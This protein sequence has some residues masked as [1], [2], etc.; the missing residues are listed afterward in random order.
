EQLGKP[1]AE[2][3][4]EFATETSV[5]RLGD[6]ADFAGMAA[7]LLSPA[8]GYVTGQTITVAG[9]LVRHITG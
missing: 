4:A 8:G 7:F 5:K 6:P 3:E 2:I 1:L 9:G